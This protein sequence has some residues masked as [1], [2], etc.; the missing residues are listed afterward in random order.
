MRRCIKYCAMIVFMVGFALM[1]IPSPSVA[2]VTAVKESTWNNWTN[3]IYYVA[4]L[5]GPGAPYTNPVVYIT[6][7]D[8]YTLYINGKLIGSDDKWDTV[9]AYPLTGTYANFFIGV[10]VENSGV[11]NGNGI[12]I[13]I[14]A[15]DDWLGT[16]LMKRR[17]VYDNS[18]ISTF[19]VQWYYFVGD[20]ET[21]LKKADWYNNDANFF[22]LTNTKGIKS[23][24]DSSLQPL[25]KWVISGNIGNTNYTPSNSHIEVVSGYDGDIDTGSTVGGGISI[26]RY[27]GENLALNRPCIDYKLVDADLIQ[28][29]AYTGSPI[30]S[31]K[32]VD[33]KDIYMINK[34]VLYTG[35]TNPQDWLTDA[36]YGFNA[37]IG[38]TE[39]YTFMNLIH[40]VGVSNA[41]NGG[42]D[43]AE[44]PFQ[45]TYAR[46]VRYNIFEARIT[47]PKIGEMMVYGSG[48]LYN[49][50]YESP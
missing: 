9:E 45:P 11:G 7:V 28:G 43:F 49:A 29:I 2:S 31:T 23:Y 46:Y 35:G 50:V 5:S 41:D 14:K 13:D 42:Y 18:I 38:I 10:K 47:P 24:K 33:L 37:E 15:G 32:Q 34:L 19:P 44:V 17:S 39:S 8:K 20:I 27:D 4:Q 36:P 3:T 30:G 22:D 1:S 48:Y 40:D 21:T 6:A 25:F 26:R 12:M 16:T